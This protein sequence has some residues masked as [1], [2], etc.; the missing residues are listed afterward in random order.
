[1]DDGR[2]TDGKGRT[3]DF[4]NCIIIATSNAGTQFIQDNIQAGKNIDEI[5]EDLINNELKEYY[6]PEFLNRFDGV[7]VFKPLSPEDI[8]K[9]TVLLLNKV[10]KRLKSKGIYLEITDEAIS[11]IAEAGFDPVFG[12]R[13]LRRVIQERVDN[14]LAN[15]LLKGKINRR[16][17]VILDKGGE[18]RVN[19]AKRV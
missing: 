8:Q 10:V 17:K 9:I 1:M 19:R 11:E 18:L 7:V 5:K 16:D 6:K 15:Y 2:L 13:P 3:V 4:T 14:A 12:A